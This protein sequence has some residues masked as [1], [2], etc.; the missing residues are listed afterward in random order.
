MIVKHFCVLET[1]YQYKLYNLVLIY[2]EKFG[3]EMLA[4]NKNP[5]NNM[6]GIFVLC[7]LMNNVGL[8]RTDDFGL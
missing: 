5:Q 2:F 3:Y 4:E 6:I 7:Q 8:Q 1:P